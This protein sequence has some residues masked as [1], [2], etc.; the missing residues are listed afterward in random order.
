MR[1]NVITVKSRAHRILR[2]LRSYS[3][4]AKDL[5]RF[6][7]RIELAM[8]RELVGVYFNPPSAMVEAVVISSDALHLIAKEGV[9]TIPFAA[10]K[11]IAGP[12]EKTEAF[13]VNIR[14][15]LGDR[16]LCRF[17]AAMT[18]SE[19]YLS[20][21]ASYRALSQ[22]KTK[23]ATPVNRT[24]FRLPAGNHGASEACG[25]RCLAAEFPL[26]GAHSF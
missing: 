21:C 10:I 19:M 15:K 18:D 17:L 22:I 3:S 2:D 13:S 16:R 8:G 11:E 9:R 7:S 5:E 23:Q 4:S 12:P 6:A 26:P 25:L 1:W 20:S 14:L 24:M